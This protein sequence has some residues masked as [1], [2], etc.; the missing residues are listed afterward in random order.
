M[1]DAGNL[2][3]RMEQTA[4]PGTVQITQDTYTLIAPLFEFE[5][6]GGITVKGKS[7][8]VLAY[9]V[10]SQKTEPG[11]LR[12]LVGLGISSPLIGREREFKNAQGTLSRLVEGKG[13]ILAVLGEAGIGKS[14]LVDE[15]HNS[16]APEE[17]ELTWLEG[18][19][20]S[21]G[22]TIS[23]WPFQEI[24]R[25][26]AGINEED[27]D[28]DAWHKLEGHIRALYP[29]EM[30]EILPY[31]A[32]LLSIE[33]SR[34]YVERVKYLDGE[35][36][37][38]QVYRAVRLFFERLA[39]ER[40][41]VLIF[42]DL[43]WMD[44]SSAGLLEH[45]LPLVE[46][47]PLLFCGLSRP[48]QAV[49]AAKLLEV[50]EEQFG[51]YL[52]VIELL[53]LSL[54]DSRHLVKNLLEIDG[55]PDQSRQMILDKADGN[56]FYLEEIVRELIDD[57][58][59][60]RDA[61]SGRWQ[62]TKRIT[63]VNVPDTIQGLLI[64]RIDRLDEKLKRVVRRAAVIGRAFLYRVL[65]AVL[66]EDRDLE[67]ELEHLQ[68]AAL[69]QEVQRIPELEYIFKHALAQEA[70]YQG[71]LLEE[72]RE[73][74][75]RVGSA[76]ETLMVDRLDEFYGLLAYHYTAAEQWEQAQEYLFK[77]GDQAGRMAADAEAL[78]HYRQAMEAYA[79]VHGD[80]WDPFERAQLERKIG[81]AFYRL[82]NFGQARSYLNRAFALLGEAMPE[83]KWGTRLAIFFALLVQLIHRL[84]PRWFVRPM[85]DPS[86]HVMELFNVANALG[87]IEGVADIERFFLI[88]VRMLNACER[89]GFAYGSTYLASSFSSAIDL[90]GL[91]GLADWYLNLAVDYSRKVEPQR[92]IFQ[93]HWSKA[94]HYNI[95]ADWDNS[96]QNA[97]RAADIAESMGD[98][99]SWGSATDLVAWAHHSQGE[100]NPARAASLEMLEVAEEGSDTQILCW[101]LLGIGVTNKR[102]G[103][104]NQAIRDLERAI[105]VSEEV[106][107]FHTQVAAGGWL[108]RCYIAKGELDKA[109]S[110]LETSQEV[111]LAS[112]VIIEI[113]ILGNGFSE[114]YLAMAERST[115]KEKQ[116][117]LKKAKRSCQDTLRAAKR[118]RPPLLDAQI[119]Q[120]RY[121]WLR[122]N[123]SAAEK[124]W[125]KALQESR[126]TRDRYAEGV[127][128][129]EIGTRLGDREHLQQAESI[130]E[131]IGAAFDLTKAR[132]A[133]ANLGES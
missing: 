15:L 7:E 104:L 116:K 65:D 36:L 127:I 54:N 98:L 95:Q 70:A 106:P 75:A 34:D 119:F 97:R 122:G 118:Y 128:Y 57:G 111:L 58:A 44:A 49:P 108:G 27:S 43:H 112:G 125:D 90:M 80:D 109:F 85:G 56:P 72:R 24:L 69:I 20:L 22:Q 13:G 66:E 91:P 3:A 100:L 40:P 45:L 5:E 77:A 73:V 67:Q 87:W 105:E 4:A 84:F 130:L 51:S 63:K 39:S 83:S 89:R 25:S 61:S 78:D 14:R 110:V 131:E 96:L 133:L 71:I 35:A 31:L 60:I 16:F 18:Q 124:W 33:V 28:T 76:I 121:E 41:L 120:G 46:R 9:R 52:T 103:K 6:L 115:G 11:R 32:S 88:A 129:L 48:D 21:Y 79:R 37:G 1:G 113:P 126:Q 29:E 53:P 92:P 99:R 93:L 8:P 10:L 68:S 101:G 23:Y 38:R 86:E 114:A 94:L 19:S 42:D 26:Y 59:L 62:A 81:E 132:E 123:S 30:A 12:G 17:T 64:A 74:H 102:F 55:I 107:D 82:G 117:W 2:A 50:A 47:I